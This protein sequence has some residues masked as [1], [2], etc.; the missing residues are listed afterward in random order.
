MLI[1][2]TRMLKG[3]GLGMAIGV[4][5]GAAGCGCM[6]GM[7]SKRKMKR[8]LMHTADVMGNTLENICC[9]MK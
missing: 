3:V 4:A 5:L 8:K 1:R 2:T 6:C 7:P 9:M